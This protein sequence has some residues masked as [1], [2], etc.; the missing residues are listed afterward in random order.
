MPVHDDPPPGARRTER[1]HESYHFHI[2]FYPPHRTP[3]K[4]KFLAGVE[5]GAGTFINDTLAEEKAAELRAAEPREFGGDNGGV[6][7]SVVE[8]N[9]SMLLNEFRRRFAGDT[10]GGA[11]PGSREPHRR[12]HGLQRW[13]RAAGGDQP[14]RPD[15]GDAAL[16]SARA[17]VLPELRDRLRIRPRPRQKIPRT[18]GATTR[19]VW[20]SNSV[21][22]VWCCAEWKASS[23]GT[24]PSPR[25]SVLRCS[26]SGAGIWLR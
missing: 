10:G 4:L 20:R 5:T 3:N 23:K 7:E 21:P 14:G 18:P 9:G 25:G 22:R 26:R 12:A 24:S 1:P 17:P 13:L 15:G 6:E 19:A 8:T 16:R 2:E 11:R